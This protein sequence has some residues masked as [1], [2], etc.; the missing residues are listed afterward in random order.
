M[1]YSTLHHFT[2]CLSETF[3]LLLVWDCFYQ[4]S[5]FVD[6]NVSSALVNT[7]R[8]KLK[9]GSAY[10]LDLLVVAAINIVL[11]VLGLPWVHGALPHSPLHAWALADREIIAVG[12][13]VTERQVSLSLPLSSLSSLSLSLSSL[14]RSSFLVPLPLLPSGLWSVS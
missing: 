11:S 7:P 13:H 1:V 4:F 14:S 12:H 3:L 2:H 10:H 8:N 5:F 9:K 6:Q